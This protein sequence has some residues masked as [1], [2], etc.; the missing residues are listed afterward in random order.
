[1]NNS[2]AWG[3]Y[4]TNF[5][6]WIGISHAGTFISA[7]LRLSRAEWRRPFTRAAEAITIFSL[8]FG[9]GSIFVD[10]GRPDRVLNV[11]TFGRLQS[12]LLWDTIC[13]STYFL[14][15]AFFFY[16]CLIPDIAICR[17]RL[18]IKGVRGMLW[19]ILALGWTGN[20]VQRARLEKTMAVLA[21]FLTML[22][23]TVHTVV[24][25]VFGMTIR[26]GW[27]TTIL[28]PYFLVGA[29][30]SG[31]AMVIIILT[32]CRKSFGLE[33]YL[34]PGHYDSLGKVLVVMTLVWFYMTFA[35]YLT[36]FYGSLA[37]EMEVFDLKFFGKFGLLF[38]TMII[39]CFVIPLA[40]L[41]RKK[42]RSVAGC[43][44]ASVSIIIG[45][46]LERFLV[47]IPT[48]TGSA[49]RGYDVGFYTPT[50][51][52]W[53]LTFSFLAAF[54]FFFAVFAKFL[55]IISVWE[56]QEGEEALEERLAKMKKLLPTGTSTAPRS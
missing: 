8:P 16:L 32:V 5:V 9:F 35:E 37:E 31:I 44:V 17:D 40:I 10:L 13:I 18:R 2:I 12:P 56:V 19:S 6:F 25:W 33:D 23:V 47:I 36:T 50:W 29:I 45:M 30:F 3:V 15:S 24:S 26:S 52:E 49:H 1:M 27:H 53:S 22:V 39:T 46:W 51:V 42:G 41:F 14:T 48:L 55:P 4:I 28:G 20:E 21:I 43:V 54:L 11:L 34:K 38:W 7:I